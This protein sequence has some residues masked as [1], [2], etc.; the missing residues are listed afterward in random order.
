MTGG[1]QKVFALKAQPA[2]RKDGMAGIL[3]REFPGAIFVGRHDTD[4][5]GVEIHERIYGRRRCVPGNGYGEV[6]EERA[7]AKVGVPFR[8]EY[9]G[10]RM[11]K[12]GHSCLWEV[13]VM[14]IP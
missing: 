13:T 2:Q 11:K 7:A 1:V 14:R 8:L 4:T 3:V 6:V 9:V 5:V 10:Q 12:P